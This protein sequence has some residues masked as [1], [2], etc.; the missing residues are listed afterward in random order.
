MR[1]VRFETMRKGQSVGSE[2]R[3]LFIAAVILLSAGIAWAQS[4]DLEVVPPTASGET[5]PSATGKTTAPAVPD[6]N[7]NILIKNLPYQP[8]KPAA[9]SATSSNSARAEV[10]NSLKLIACVVN[11]FEQKG[12]SSEDCRA[13]GGHEAVT[14]EVLGSSSSKK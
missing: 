8:E 13:R 5:T 11:G 7:R 2:M 14:P 1:N 9:V 6:L 4:N 10:P 12:V 3:K